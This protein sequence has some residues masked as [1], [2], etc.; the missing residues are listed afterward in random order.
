MRTLNGLD[1]CGRACGYQVRPK[2]D[3]V[4]FPLLKQNSREVKRYVKAL[5]K[6]GGF[7]TSCPKEKQ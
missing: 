6:F 2:V 3:S 1:F 5:Q 7:T 4:I